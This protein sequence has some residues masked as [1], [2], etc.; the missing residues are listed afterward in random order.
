MLS[1]VRF[2]CAVSSDNWAHP[3]R[4]RTY[5]AP[6][7]ANTDCKIWEAVRATTAT[8][9]IFKSIDIAGIGGI[10]EHFIDAGTKCNNPAK[11]VVDE[12]R[13]LFGYDR[14]FVVIS[15]GAGHPGVIGLPKPDRFPN[16]LPL[17]LI[18]ALRDIA[19]NCEEVASELEK[20][21]N[22]LPDTYLR[23]DVTHGLV[24][25]EEWDP[26][27]M[28]AL[29]THTKSYLAEFRVSKAVDSAVQR[30][31]ESSSPLDIIQHRPNV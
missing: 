7:N 2:V 9:G 8:P 24:S 22:E 23:F 5:T 14:A 13:N 30:L 1:A 20:Q 29:T 3:R 6:K 15:I 16:L 11:V 19:T 17:Q 12:A 18:T 25:L 28:G 21:F 27:N 26:K 10:K 4:F 31:C